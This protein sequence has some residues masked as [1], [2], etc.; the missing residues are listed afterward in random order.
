M[1][2]GSNLAYL[3]TLQDRSLHLIGLPAGPK[4]ARAILEISPEVADIG[5]GIV[6]L[7]AGWLG[8][9]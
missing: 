4:A 5:F 2:A 7:V 8:T 6:T 1:K 9:V 3:A